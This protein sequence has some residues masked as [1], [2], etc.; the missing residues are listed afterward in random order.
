MKNTLLDEITYKYDETSF[1]TW[2]SFGYSTGEVFR[3][4]KS[5]RELFGLPLVHYTY[6]RCPETGSR[7]VAKGILAIGRLAFGVLAIGHVSLGIVAIGQL[8][9][10]LLLGLGQAST[11]VFAVGQ[12]AIGLLFGLGQLA[13][14]YACIAQIGL[15]Q[16]VLA[17]FGFGA[18]VWDMRGSTPAARRYFQW[19]IPN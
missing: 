12:L 13:T 19:L 2:R 7:V 18:E 3:E 6:G 1:G 11:G 8:G 4:F 15:G 9:I 10:G 5:H 16:F 17:Q 14:G